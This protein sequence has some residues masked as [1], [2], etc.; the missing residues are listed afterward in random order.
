M[1]IF[2]KLFSPV[3]LIFSISILTYTFY[4]SE[5][6]WDGNNK[7]YYY[8]Y[9]IISILLIFFSILTFFMNQELKKKL[10][11]I[12]ISILISLYLIEVYLL[13]G[14][15]YF[16]KKYF[17]KFNESQI[18]KSKIYEEKSNKKWDTRTFRQVYEDELKNNNQVVLALAPVLIKLDNSLV[19]FLSGIENSLTIYCNENGYYPIYFS[20]RYGF[21]NPDYEWESNEIEY[22]IVGDS[23]AQGLCVNRPD[24]ISSTMRII[25]KKSSLTL[26][27]K[28]NGPLKTYA[29][30]REYLQP[31][32]KKII[33]IYYEGNDLMDL[34]LELK[35]S[36]LKS[37]INDLNFS[38]NLKLKANI[39][40]KEK[41]K[42]FYENF[43]NEKLNFLSF[44]KIYKLR[45]FLKNKIFN[46]INI[47]NSKQINDS[48]FSTF[49]KIITLTKNL[50]DN[51]DSKLYFAYIPEYSRFKENFDN[52]NYKLIKEIIYSL[53]IPFI[54]LKK[55]FE[56]EEDPLKFF[57]FRLDGHYNTAGYK[58]ISETI[59]DFDKNK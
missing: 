3:I 21:N 36:I 51:N 53:D 9:Y 47:I 15:D 14:H 35:N 43:I 2:I 55:T 28:G 41:D 59:Y 46:N 12:I 54:D 58:K 7:N 49:K 33:W 40:K 19:Y 5:I 56:K 29:S 57:P 17:F 4:R 48:T 10:I 27:W 20:D 26:G 24:D 30:L 31:N 39:L 8:Y 11:I 1:N 34:E 44:I 50:S 6:Y 45:K 37:Y 38:Q 25:S 42:I 13:F 23:F 32:V 22:L 16:S 18:F 52:T